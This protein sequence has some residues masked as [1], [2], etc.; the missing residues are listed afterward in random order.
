MSLRTVAAETPRWCRSSSALEPTGS[1][2]CDVVLDDGAQ[3][4]QPAVLTH[5]A[6][7]SGTSGTDGMARVLALSRAECQFYGLGPTRAN[8]GDPRRGRRVASPP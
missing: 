5:H 6:V 1:E 2:V 3:H 7:T 8:A 4:A